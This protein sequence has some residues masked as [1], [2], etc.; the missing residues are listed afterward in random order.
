MK[1]KKEVV[2]NKEVFLY[3]LYAISLEPSRPTTLKPILLKEEINNLEK[4]LKTL[5]FLIKT[6]LFLLPTHYN[7][8]TR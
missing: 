1:T 6:I 5:Q 2:Q 7:N 3:K 8:L 4:L